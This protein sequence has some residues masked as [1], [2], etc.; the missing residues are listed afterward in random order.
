MIGIALLGAGRMGQL[1][2]RNIRVHPNAQ[3]VSVFDTNMS[4]AEALADFAG[5]QPTCDVETAINAEGTQAALIC[6]P[7]KT[8][9]D[10]ILKAVRSNRFVLCE[11]PIDLD[12]ANA[13]ACLQELGDKASRVMMA[14]NRRF[15]PSQAHI[16]RMVRSGEIG[17]VEQMI[18]ICRDPAPPPPEY[19]RTCGGIFRDM[20]IHDFD[21]ARAI[22]GINF[23][24]VH[25]YHPVAD[26]RKC[27]AEFF[28]R[29]TQRLRHERASEL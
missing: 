10:Y 18:I 14:F 3:V 28:C 7:T 19:I 29:Q 4:A 24:S 6:S 22:T 9:V 17:S 13:A 16:R 2:A 25:P 5:A 1:H 27:C 20:M 15:D 21:Q 12:T 11:K 26:C 23:V 8:H